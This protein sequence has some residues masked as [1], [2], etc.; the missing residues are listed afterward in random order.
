[1]SEGGDAL[2]LGFAER[3]M[4]ALNQEKPPDAAW[5]L[6][7]SSGYGD[8]FWDG[9]RFESEKCKKKVANMESERAT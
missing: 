4:E 8:G 1:M 5:I 7:Y 6:A 9:L 3:L 2:K